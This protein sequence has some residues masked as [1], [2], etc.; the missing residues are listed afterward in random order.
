LTSLSKLTIFVF[1]ATSNLTLEVF[2]L[3]VMIKVLKAQ[4]LI[5]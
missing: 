1:Y 5:T 4:K 2:K 3:K